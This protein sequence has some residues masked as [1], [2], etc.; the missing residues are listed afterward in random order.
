M[1]GGMA[2]IMKRRKKALQIDKSISEL[3]E[4]RV[5]LLKI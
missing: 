4:R 3:F 5:R 2:R 1:R